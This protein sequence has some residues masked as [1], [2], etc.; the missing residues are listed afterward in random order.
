VTR[1]GKQNAR[2]KGDLDVT[3][4]VSVVD[5]IA[6]R[7]GRPRAWKYALLAA[8]FVGWVALL[9]YFAAAGAPRPL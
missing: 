1:G 5:G 7:T 4:P 8:A 2:G 3:D 9:I 6:D